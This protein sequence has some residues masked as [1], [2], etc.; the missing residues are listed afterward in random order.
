MWSFYGVALR[1]CGRIA[2]ALAAYESGLRA[3]SGRVKPDT[4]EWREHLRILLLGLMAVAHAS[5]GDER[6]RNAAFTR[7]FRAQFDLI[8]AGGRTEPCCFRLLPGTIYELTAMHTRRC[9][10]AVIGP[11]PRGRAANAGQMMYRIEEVAPSAEL[12]G[13]P[14]TAQRIAALTMVSG[15]ESHRVVDRNARRGAPTAALPAAACRV[16]G[17]TPAKHC[18]ACMGPA[19]CGRECQAGDWASHKA[20]CRAARAAKAAAAASGSA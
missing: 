16:C 5:A 18:A 8:T 14:L 10:R 15:R 6:G 9:W 20:A 1:K 4:P 13:Q 2:E 7:L 17:K 12:V 11:D 19:Y 3:I